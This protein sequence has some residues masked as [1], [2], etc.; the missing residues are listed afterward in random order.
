[1]RY[2]HTPLPRDL[3]R[4]RNITLPSKGMA[5]LSKMKR[6]K[7]TNQNNQADLLNPSPSILAHLLPRSLLLR[8]HFPSTHL[9]LHHLLLLVVPF[10]GMLMMRMM[11]MRLLRL[12]VTKM[13]MMMTTMRKTQQGIP[14]MMAKPPHHAGYSVII[15]HSYTK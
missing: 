12:Q 9:L 3:K 2:S 5:Y 1:M 4:Y 13:M 7:P 10:R 14:T 8:V 11:A 6:K 15:Q